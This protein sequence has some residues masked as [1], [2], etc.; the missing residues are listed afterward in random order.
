MKLRN[1]LLFGLLA[2]ALLIW[3]CSD[4]DDG[5]TNNN[6]DDVNIVDQ[7]IG[8]EGGNV[9]I[10]GK[11][12]LTVPAG[13]LSDIVTF[14]IE[15]NNSPAGPGG[16]LG[17]LSSAYSIEPSGTNFSTPAALVFYYDDNLVGQAGEGTVVL[18]CDSG[19]GVW[20]TVS[21]TVDTVHNQVLASI[22]HLSDY[23]V[24]GDT[25]SSYAEGV[26]GILCVSRMINVFE[27]FSLA[28]DGIAARFD[29]AYAPCEAVKSLHPDSIV[30][31]NYGL[32]WEEITSQYQYGFNFGGFISPEHDYVF[33]VY[34]SSEVPSLVDTIEFPSCQP[35]L[36]APIAGDTVTKAG[37]DVTWTNVCGGVVRIT[38]LQDES[39]SVLS[40]EVSNSAG[41]HTFDNAVLSGMTA[42]EYG[43]VLVHQNSK[44]IDAA[45][46]DSRSTIMARSMCN[47]TFYLKD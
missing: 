4:D 20:E 11:V 41:S 26:Y 12:V 10:A 25:L 33:T 9:F 27:E 30:C 7:Q 45:G 31:D 37:F 34:G 46:Y 28:F 1:I 17:F 22:S 2:L 5:V 44:N 6:D 21:A 18:G 14:S 43:I 40:V 19:N 39:D 15:K 36:T 47:S 3:G 32:E 8:P 23:A 29:S 13:A 38:L 16:T 42:G 24:L 35:T